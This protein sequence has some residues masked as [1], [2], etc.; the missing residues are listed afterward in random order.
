MMECFDVP[1]VMDEIK[2]LFDVNLDSTIFTF[3]DVLYNPRH[4]LYS[5]DYV[6]HE[7]VHAGQ[8]GHTPEG[9]GKWWARYFQDPYFRIQQEAEAYGAQYAYLQK[10]DKNRERV[11]RAVVWFSQALSGPNYGHVIGQATALDMIKKCAKIKHK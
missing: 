3:G 2:R 7:E 10:T 8:Q 6:K 1:P 9:A 5:F 11:N 4:I